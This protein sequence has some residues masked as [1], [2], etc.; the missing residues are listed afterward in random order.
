MLSGKKNLST[1]IAAKIIDRLQLSKS[2]REI[3]MLSVEF[4]NSRSGELKS[5][6]A[7]KI[8]TIADQSEHQ[9]GQSFEPT[10]S[11][12][13]YVIEDTIELSS[14]AYRRI[15]DLLADARDLAKKESLNQTGGRTYR[16]NIHF[17]RLKS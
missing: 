13:L 7:Q 2:E 11:K 5:L 12:E 10:E 4:E 16:L 15:R 6:V 14:E 3:F 9:S 17:F 1:R 8:Q